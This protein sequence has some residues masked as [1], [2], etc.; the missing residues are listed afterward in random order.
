MMRVSHNLS[1]RYCQDCIRE[2][3]TDLSLCWFCFQKC[4]KYEKEMFAREM[5][6]DQL[7]QEIDPYERLRRM[8]NK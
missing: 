5:S 4:N 2:I 1:K 7:L 8:Q 6:F 3:D